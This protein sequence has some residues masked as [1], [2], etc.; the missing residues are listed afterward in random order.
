MTDVDRGTRY[1]AFLSYSHKDAAVARWLHRK[2]ETYRI[3]SRLVGTEGERGAVPARLT[4]IFRDREELPAA[5]DLSEKVRAALAASDNLIVICSP[6]SS[7][8]PWVAKEIATFR[9]LHPNRPVFAAI[10]EADPPQCFPSGLVEGGIEPLAADLRKGGDGQRLGL[11]KL[12]AG[13][14]GIGLDT[15][16]Q[17]DAARRIRRISYLTA[18]AVAAMMLMALLTAYA[19]NA[20]AEAQRQRAEAEGLVEFMLTDLRNRLRAVGRVD[21]METVNRRALARYGGGEALGSLSGEQLSRR[22]RFLHAIAEDQITLGDT[23]KAGTAAKEA[24]RTTT[25]Q[26]SRQPRNPQRQLEHA[27]STYWIGRVHEVRKEWSQ[28][29]RQYALFATATDRLVAADPSNAEYMREVGWSRIDLGNVQL[30]GTKD[31]AR[32]QHYYE[33]AIAWFRRALTTRPD[34]ET[35]RIL[36]NAY[37]WLA[38]S[39]YMRGHYPASLDARQRQYRIA[40]ALHYKY[41]RDADE[42]YRFAIAR[43]AVA[44]SLA[45]LGRGGEARTE[46]IEAGAIATRL[47]DRDPRNGEWLMLRAM[48][49]CDLLYTKA[50]ALPAASRGYY[51]T[52]VLAAAR[53][54][55]QAGNA[56]VEELSN[57]VRAIEKE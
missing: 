6:H 14:A 54:L 28:A 27:R 31:F 2:L 57:C 5:G 22:A 36:A 35:A 19:V 42:Y 41:P 53:S 49:G 21:I 9:A 26:L 20:R 45:K 10:I 56:R 11:L 52:H 50:V 8:S 4:P 34:D 44:K 13:L 37:G 17:R 46:L 16:V 23:D 47:S 30:N 33:E 48:I 29:Q 51:R 18:G 3:P 15:L 32:A 1:T 43:R 12:V 40:S 24:Y 38:D 7:A 25:E 55:R 39:F